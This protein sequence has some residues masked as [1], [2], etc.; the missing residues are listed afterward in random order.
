MGHHGEDL[1]R[2]EG[3]EQTAQG[4]LAAGRA[5]CD[6]QGPEP[7]VEGAGVRP[8]PRGSS[9]SRNVND[10]DHGHIVFCFVWR[11][12]LLSGSM[13]SRAWERVIYLYTVRVST[14]AN[15]LM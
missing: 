6:S 14:Y 8:R 13:L 12:F 1:R 9:K 4:R 3:Q 2:L 10:D 5:R 7:E 11:D 15:T